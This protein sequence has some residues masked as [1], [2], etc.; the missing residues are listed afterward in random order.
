[1]KNAEQW[2]AAFYPVP[3]CDTPKEQAI[4]ASLRKWRGLEPEVLE[5]YGLRKDWLFIDSGTGTSHVL[6]IDGY[7][8]A[9]CEHYY[10]GDNECL[11]CPLAL[12]R[13][14]VACDHKHKG[15]KRAPYFHWSETG[16][17]KPMIA[18]LEAAL[19]W[20]KEHSK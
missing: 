13:G 18:A 10:D 1:M 7:T 9:L 2:L 8:C 16:D 20:E 3:A 19:V 6:T 15:E 4:E 17:P 14:G 11:S 12:S 5:D